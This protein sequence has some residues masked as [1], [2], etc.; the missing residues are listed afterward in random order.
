METTETNPQEQKKELILGDEFE[1]ALVSAAEVK[2]TNISLC[3]ERNKTNYGDFYELMLASRRD[4]Q[5]ALEKKGKAKTPDV[6][7][8]IKNFK[9]D[10]SQEYKQICDLITPE[11]LE[12]G[13]PTKVQKMVQKI[14]KVVKMMAY[15]GHT[16]IEDEFKKEGITLS[17]KPLEEENDMFCADH[18]KKNI[19]SVFKTGK[20]IREDIN[21]NNEEIRT[22]IYESSVPVDLQYDK[23]CNPTGIK[24][25]DFCKL[26]DLKAKIMKAQD[27]ESKDKAKESAESIAEEYVFQNARNEILNKKLVEISA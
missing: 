16:E 7:E 14:S 24:S 4:V 12:E 25:S 1:K 2:N 19:S 21:K 17:Y 13:M 9:K 6:K 20:S 3:K 11:E 8:L 10:V 5:E 15:I 26:V 27:E 22:N 18:I 23:Q